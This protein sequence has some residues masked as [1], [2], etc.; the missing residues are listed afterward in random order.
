M[1][2]VRCDSAPDCFACCLA[3]LAVTRLKMDTPKAA[4]DTK[5]AT[6]SIN[7]TLPV[8]A[9]AVSRGLAVKASGTPYFLQVIENIGAGEGNRTLV[10]SLEGCGPK[11]LIKPLCRPE[12]QKLARSELVYSATVASLPISGRSTDVEN[13]VGPPRHGEAVVYPSVRLC[14]GFLP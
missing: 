2:S 7:V 9:A 3:C 1:A 14:L 13:L 12:N 11:R 4:K 5:S 6:V 10:I 8:Y